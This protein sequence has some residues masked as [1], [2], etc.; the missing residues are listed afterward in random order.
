M[1]VHAIRARQIME[2]TE[3]SVRESEAMSNHAAMIAKQSWE[4]S[5]AARTILDK[6]RRLLLLQRA[7]LGA[8][9]QAE[10][11]EYPDFHSK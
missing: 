9:G 10:I 2:R 8:L 7:T 11:L 1:G 4:T 3:R 6:Q 5:L